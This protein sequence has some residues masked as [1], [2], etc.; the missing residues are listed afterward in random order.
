[1]NQTTRLKGDK[2]VYQSWLRQVGV[3]IEHM[4]EQDAKKIAFWCAGN[5]KHILAQMRVAPA[6]VSD[7]TIG[8]VL[9]VRI[10]SGER[11]SVMDDGPE[12]VTV[13]IHYRKQ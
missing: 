6:Y 4:R 12:H 2:L 3:Q 11:I 13:T 7:T 9:S 8:N 10:K 1:M 5:K